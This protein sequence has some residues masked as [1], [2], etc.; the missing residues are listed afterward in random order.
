LEHSL[1][2]QSNKQYAVDPMLQI[3]FLL[4]GEEHTGVEEVTKHDC[5][6][7]L[8][9]EGLWWNIVQGQEKRHCLEETNLI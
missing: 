5:F 8:L 3:R 9:M 4:D 2:Q 7:L 1:S 6:A